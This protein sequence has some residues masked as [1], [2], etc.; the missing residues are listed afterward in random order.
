MM[1]TMLRCQYPL[2]KSHDVS[3][4]IGFE[5]CRFLSR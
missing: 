2:S 5:R 3:M 1:V 4:A